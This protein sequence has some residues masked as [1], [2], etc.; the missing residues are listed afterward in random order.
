MATTAKQL[1][2][3]KK[4]YAHHLW[5]KEHH[6][7]SCAA[8]KTSIDQ[9]VPSITYGQKTAP[10][11]NVS[12]TS[13]VSLTASSTSENIPAQL[14]DSL[15]SLGDES[16][17]D[18][19]D[20]SESSEGSISAPLLEQVKPK[21]EE[22][23]DAD[24]N[25]CT[26]RKQNMTLL[27]IK[28]KLCNSDEDFESHDNS[29][30]CPAVNTSTDKAV[31]MTHTS[32]F[33]DDKDTPGLPNDVMEFSDNE[34]TV[35][36]PNEIMFFSD[37]EEKPAVT[38]NVMEFSESLKFPFVKKQTMEVSDEG[39]SNQSETHQYAIRND[40]LLL[41]L[42]TVAASTTDPDLLFP[43]NVFPVSGSRLTEE[44]FLDL[45]VSDLDLKPATPMPP[46]VSLKLKTPENQQSEREVLKNVM[47]LTKTKDLNWNLV[48]E[49][50][51]ISTVLSVLFQETIINSKARPENVDNNAKATSEGIPV[52]FFP[53]EQPFSVSRAENQ[54]P[55]VETLCKET[56]IDTMN[57]PQSTC[58]AE[59]LG[60][61]Y[62]PGGR[63]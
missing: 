11:T 37:N 39:E 34:K 61:H 59:T 4:E 7:T 52:L 26:V 35:P 54:L 27:E 32:E 16:P 51:M 41:E 47:S 63:C 46:A 3:L 62:N 18:S 12:A 1:E 58:N 28:G 6:A 57:T 49:D 10:V 36:F 17:L 9:I 29:S 40:S 23:S 21:E 15:T 42:D 25:S 30:P 50:L 5:F 43:A 24:S 2:G 53:K 33:S 45:L 48:F 19:K 38:K 22:S 55:V 14:N 44:Q 56:F 60:G 13:S 8:P 20:D 31:Q